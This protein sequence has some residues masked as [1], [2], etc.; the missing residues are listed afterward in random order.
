[1][2]L[3]FQLETCTRHVRVALH[4]I[5]VARQGSGNSTSPVTLPPVS[6]SESPPMPQ[7]PSSM[8]SL[9]VRSLSNDIPAPQSMSS[10]QPDTPTVTTPVQSMSLPQPLQRLC[11]LLL[12]PLFLLYVTLLFASLLTNTNITSSLRVNLP[13]TPSSPPQTKLVAQR[14]TASPHIL[15]QATHPSERPSL[16]LMAQS[17]PQ[18]LL[19]GLSPP[20]SCRTCCSRLRHCLIPCKSFLVHM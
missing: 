19:L 20:Q 10:S 3:C 13:Q 6:I 2:N 15:Q 17:Q 4:R 14:P 16:P 18:A 12:L 8:S 9:V 11:L 5:L 1:V 7:I